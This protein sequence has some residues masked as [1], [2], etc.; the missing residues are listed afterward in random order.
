M[1][2]NDSCV[3][4]GDVSSSHIRQVTTDYSVSYWCVYIV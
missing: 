1:F 2:E 3:D 4:Y